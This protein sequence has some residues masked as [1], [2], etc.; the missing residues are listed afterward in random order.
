MRSVKKIHYKQR[1]IVRRKNIIITSAKR[2]KGYREM[3]A[4]IVE[5]VKRRERGS[6]KEWEKGMSKEKNGRK[7]IKK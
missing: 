1:R 5:E 7:K 2:G 6:G 4:E 3:I